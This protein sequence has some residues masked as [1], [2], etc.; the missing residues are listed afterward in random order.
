MLG[1]QP[2]SGFARLWNTVCRTCSCGKAKFIARRTSALSNGGILALSSIQIMNEAG[3]VSTAT[4]GAFCRSMISRGC[5]YWAMSTAP[6]RR[7]WT[8]AAEVGTS[9]N[10]TVSIA[11]LPP[12]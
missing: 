4:F 1:M 7:S 12:Q 10:T 11:G 2:L 6:P 3:T 8:R 9:L 5:R